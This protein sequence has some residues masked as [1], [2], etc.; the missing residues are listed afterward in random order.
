MNL[1]PIFIL[2]ICLIVVPGFASA[3]PQ[4]L[5]MLQLGDSLTQGVGRYPSYRE[6]LRF[7][8]KYWWR[9]YSAQSGKPSNSITYVGSELHRCTPK[10]PS[11]PFPV[12]P[13]QPSQPHEGH[14]S[15]GSTAISKALSDNVASYP[16]S[17]TLSMV[18]M[19]HNDAF[20]VARLCKLKEDLR[21]S[22]V[23]VRNGDRFVLSLQ[24]RQTGSELIKPENEDT[25]TPTIDGIF[26]AAFVPKEQMA[27]RACV[28]NHLG[29]L[30]ENVKAVLSALLKDGT[31][32][33]LHEP[34]VVLWGLNPP[35]GFP[36][37]DSELRSVIYSACSGYAHSV[38]PKNSSSKNSNTNL[39][40]CRL[41]AFEGFL[42][43]THTFDSTHPNDDGATLMAAAWLEG[44][45]QVYVSND[46][47]DDTGAA[48]DE[49]NVG[50]PKMTSVIGR[51]NEAK[52]ATSSSTQSPNDP[53]TFALVPVLVILILS[54][55]ILLRRWI[56]GSRRGRRS[57]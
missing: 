36:V 22:V 14:C 19:G 5:C 13:E 8:L 6:I 20:Q 1:G 4:G 17:P 21:G 29:T 28:A 33:Q 51:L 18:L 9:N 41:V 38:L 50:Y 47:A 10:Q 26:R 42:P 39:L 25:T 45:Q 32:S 27:R 2:A 53:T 31:S 30:A 15:R 55:V 37:I 23:A 52:R 34:K 35:V 7:P 24:D 12:N 44:V 56:N 49:A 43:G 48:S 40:V 16:C 11:I 46:F 57:G 54:A 3:D